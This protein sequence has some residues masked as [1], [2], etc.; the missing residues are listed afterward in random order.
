MEV[1]KNEWEAI[2]KALQQWEQNGD[3][4]PEKVSDL[5]NTIV[6]RRTEREQIAQYFFFV[7]LFCTLM[8]FGAIFI[9]EKLLERIKLYFSW[10]DW[11]IAFITAALAVIWFIYVGRKRTRLSLIAYEVNMVL[12]GLSVLT[13]LIYVCKQF[14]T[15]Q[16]FV[17]FFSLSF[18]SLGILSVIFRS[19]ALWIGALLSLVAWFGAFTTWQSTNDLFLAMNYPL[20]YTVFGGL[21]VLLS[22]VQFRIPRLVYAQRVTYITGMFVFF[23]AIWGLSV[24]GNYNTLVRWQQVRQVHVLAYSVIFAAA[25]SLSFYLGV[26][27]RDDLAKDLG[28]L[29]LLINLYTRYFEYFWD[30]MN[31]GIFFLI[32]AITFGFLGWWLERKKKHKSETTPVTPS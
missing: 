31:K 25:A 29:F 12:G 6:L 23:T 10:N 1:D 32:L 22:F 8:A 16:S 5:K 17:A 14:H 30:T 18:I 27:F 28:V 7:A 4:P 3:L 11:A 2:Q 20:R 13:S 19:L 9:N 15:D 24:F 21:M 26:R